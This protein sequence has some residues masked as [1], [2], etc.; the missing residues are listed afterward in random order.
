MRLPLAQPFK[1]RTGAPDKDSRL[2]NSYIEVK[3]ESGIVRK[4]PIA[5]GGVSVGTGTAQGGIGF[6]INGTPYFIG[7]WGDTLVNYTGGGTSWD[8]G[9][10]YPQGSMVSVGFTNYWAINDNTNS[11]PPNSNWSTTPVYNTPSVAVTYA[12]L[13]SYT[14][15]GSSLSNGGLTFS[16]V[17]GIGAYSHIACRAGV[18]TISL[19]SGKWYWEVTLT[20]AN[21]CGLGV[22][23]GNITNANVGAAV[24]EFGANF[25]GN[26]YLTDPYNAPYKLNDS[27]PSAYSSTASNG[28]VIGVAFD[29]DNG[30]LTFYKNGVSQGVAFSS[31]P[32]PVY[33][34]IDE[35]WDI[36]YKPLVSFDAAYDPFGIDP[37]SSLSALTVNFGQSA[38]SYSP[39][40]G[41]NHGVYQ[42]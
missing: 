28:V 38:F 23:Y 8:S 32:I 39:P 41:F 29:I 19:N 12:I 18:Q 10:T 30:T 31:I 13:D 2:K 35:S 27:T 5:Q 26:Q 24:D 14:G 4:R 11:Q 40:V 16:R 9:T 21:L 17:S 36:G 25:T 33:D 20:T 15:T 6:Y 3:G 42:L 37:D 22:G 7:F 1:T 34:P